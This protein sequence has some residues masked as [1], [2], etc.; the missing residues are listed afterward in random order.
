MRNAHKVSGIESLINDELK[1][2]FIQENIVLKCYV[3]AN[4]LISCFV[5][6]NISTIFRIK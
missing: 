6:D 2:R 3:L 1:M 4:N 5:F